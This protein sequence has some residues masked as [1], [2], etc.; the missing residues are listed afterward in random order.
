MDASQQS[1]DVSTA[2]SALDLAPCER[3]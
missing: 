1:E 3:E 2:L